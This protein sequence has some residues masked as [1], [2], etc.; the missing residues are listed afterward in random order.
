MPRS[1][2]GLL[3]CVAFPIVFSLVVRVRL[4]A[5]LTVVGPCSSRLRG[6][7]GGGDNGRYGVVMSVN[8]KHVCALFLF[9]NAFF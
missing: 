6:V 7:V 1:L 4:L 2:G 9:P 3:G 5:L 8:T